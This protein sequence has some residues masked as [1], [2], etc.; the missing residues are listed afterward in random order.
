MRRTQTLPLLPEYPVPADLGYQEKG[1]WKDRGLRF[2][3]RVPVLSWLPQIH[4]PRLLPL[5]ASSSLNP[6]P[7]GGLKET[8]ARGTG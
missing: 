6:H 3:P 7:Y 4:H 1:L 5:L 2:K 8:T